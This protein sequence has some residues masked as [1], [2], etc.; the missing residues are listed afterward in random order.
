MYQYIL[1]GS[2]VIIA[3]LS[4]IIKTCSTKTEK[5]LLQALVLKEEEKQLYLPNPDPLTLIYTHLMKNQNYFLF[6]FP[7]IIY[8]VAI[9]FALS[10]LNL[11]SE[12]TNSPV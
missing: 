8:C 2:F 7:F 1:I 11:L 12:N 5:K 3:P 6:C 9:C 10:P 4:F